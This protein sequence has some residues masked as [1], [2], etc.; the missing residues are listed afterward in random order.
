MLPRWSSRVRARVGTD[1]VRAEWW[2]GW[3]RPVRVHSVE[4]E[5]DGAAALDAAIEK[6]DVAFARLAERGARL[7]GARCEVVLADAW[8]LYDVIDADLRDAPVRVA[9]ETI[10]A[11]LADIAGVAPAALDVRWQPQSA[12]Y[13]ACALPAAAMTALARVCAKHRLSLRSVIG[14]LVDVFN[15][16][17]ARVATDASDWMLAVVRP[18]GAQFALWRDGALTATSFEP[19]ARDAAALERHG[20]ALARRAG[21]EEAS[22]RCYADAAGGCAMPAGWIAVGSG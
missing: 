18:A 3:R 9:D 13:A 21:I 17:R 2:R 6:L 22:V 15:E 11:A 12:R 7:G 20:R 19:A 16:Q 5:T 4:L 1:A 10:R 8:L 14:E